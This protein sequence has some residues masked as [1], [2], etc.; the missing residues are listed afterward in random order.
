[1]K[2]AIADKALKNKSTVSVILAYF[3]SMAYKN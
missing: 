1:M 3:K 2:M